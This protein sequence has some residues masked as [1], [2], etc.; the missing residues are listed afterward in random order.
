MKIEG[1]STSSVGVVV[2]NFNGDGVLE[3][4]VASLLMSPSVAEVIVVD[5]ASSDSSVE[6][7]TRYVS[8]LDVTARVEIVETN[9]NLGYGRACNLGA[10]RLQSSYILIS[11]PDI[12][13][14]SGSIEKL[15]EMAIRRNLGG[16]GP[17]ILNPDHSRYP[18]VRPF[19][20]LLNAAMHSVLGEIW[21]ANPFSKRYKV[22][23]AQT[24]FK[25]R[26]ISGASILM[27]IE[28]YRSV[29]GFDHR[30][31][32]Y[33]EDVDLCTRILDN[34]FELGYCD[35]ALAIHY[36]GFSSKQRPYFS[37]YAHHR[38]LAIYAMS[39]LR[40]PRR[41]LLPLVLL[42]VFVRFAIRIGN[43]SIRKK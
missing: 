42:G 31:F 35:E 5:N 3:R 8:S 12:V 25:D 7:L 29:G 18:S 1:G 10:R 17:M 19:P 11:N 27:P 6:N 40:G 23:F 38:S 36:Q 28:L 34:G 15:L 4:C 16:V 26:W 30:Y 43:I 13:Y 9:A 33:M 39:N 20:S 2:V 24:T 14:E 32:M 41:L 22:D 21:P 37:A